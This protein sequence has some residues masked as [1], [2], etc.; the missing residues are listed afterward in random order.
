LAVSGALILEFVRQRRSSVTIWS[1]LKPS[2]GLMGLTTAVVFVALLAQLWAYHYTPVAY[3]EAIKRSIG[4]IGAVTVGWWMFD[5][6][7]IY[8]RLAA[9]SV[10]A[11]GV[12][13]IL[14]SG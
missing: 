8:R 9:V 4:M 10:M 13:L 11:L 1:A 3:V 7:S 6:S 5:E 14:L 2:T 12:S